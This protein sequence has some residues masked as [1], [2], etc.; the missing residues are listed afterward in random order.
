MPLS[1]RKSRKC[2][3]IAKWSGAQEN[4][5]QNSGQNNIITRLSRERKLDLLP[6][7]SP[8]HQPIFTCISVVKEAL[9]RVSIVTPSVSHVGY[10][11]PHGQ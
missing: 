2:K 4:S 1:K 6:K 11:S 7:L 8:F 5:G 9:S 3:Q 10:D